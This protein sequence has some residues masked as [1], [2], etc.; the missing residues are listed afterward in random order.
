MVDRGSPAAHSLGR[1][2]EGTWATLVLP[3][4]IGFDYKSR[5]TQK[6]G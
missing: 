2:M 6:F 1:E 4:Y 5:S 3:V